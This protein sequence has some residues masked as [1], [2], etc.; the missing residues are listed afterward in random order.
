MHIS[1]F[2]KGHILLKKTRTQYD[3]TKVFSETDIVKIIRCLIDNIFVM[4]GECM[5]QQTV[6]IPM[7]INC[8]LLLVDFYLYMHETTEPWVPIGDVE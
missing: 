8:V 1:S 2:R 6:V 7:E 5:F 3:Y 4:L